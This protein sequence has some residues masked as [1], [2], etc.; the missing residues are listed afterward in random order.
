M[1]TPP[2]INR[3]A[4]PELLRELID[5][6]GEAA[7]FALI[8]WRG[9]AYLSVP[10]RVDP[11]HMLIEHIG[12]VAFVALVERFGGET[13]MLPKKDA[14]TRQ[15][16]HQIVRQLRQERLTVDQIAIRT[17]YTMRR[18]FQI[19]GEN[20]AEPSSGDLFE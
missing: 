17:G 4:L 5:C 3:A 9:G 13:V 1:N 14:V 2:L 7:A 16:R 18:V 19:L 11:Q 10:K 12:P 15:Q 6:V 20:P 8:D